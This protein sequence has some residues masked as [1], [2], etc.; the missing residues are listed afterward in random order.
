MQ[1]VAKN[2]D[3]KPLMLPLDRHGGKG[4]LAM[5]NDP[6]LAKYALAHAAAGNQNPCNGRAGFQLLLTPR[7]IQRRK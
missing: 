6:A 4:R 1:S 2:P 5:T 7:G 3:A